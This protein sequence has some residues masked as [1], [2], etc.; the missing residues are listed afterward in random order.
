[1][2]SHITVRHLKAIPDTLE[3]RVLYVSEEFETA[4]RLRGGGCGSK[5][6][7][8]LGKTEAKLTW[9]SSCAMAEARTSWQTCSR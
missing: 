8:P 4:H 2:I 6:R 1:V 7:T 5:V 9:S 3:P